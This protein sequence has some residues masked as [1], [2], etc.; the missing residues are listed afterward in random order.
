MNEQERYDLFSELLTRDQS[1]I[2]GYIF[3]LIR[4]RDDAADL[5]QSVCLLLWRKFAA[6]QPGSS[7]FH[8]ARQVSV[9][10]VRNFL[11]RKRQPAHVSEQLLDAFAQIPDQ[12]RS[13][14]TESYLVALRRCKAH[15]DLGYSS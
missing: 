5:F 11:K 2:Y 1:R 4:N 3:A 6:F 15:A 12:I 8:W 9:F 7:F 13:D 14:T 10:E